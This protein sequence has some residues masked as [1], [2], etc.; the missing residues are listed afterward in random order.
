VNKQALEAV[1]EFYKVDRITAL[2]LYWDEIKAMEQW[3]LN[4]G[5]GFFIEESDNAEV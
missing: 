5:L 1:M 3:L 2:Q 4:K